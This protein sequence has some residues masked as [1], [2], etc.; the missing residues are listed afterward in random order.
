MKSPSLLS[1]LIGGGL[2]GFLLG[3]SVGV[4]PG[5]FGESSEMPVEPSSAHWIGTE[6]ESGTIDLTLSQMAALHAW[7]IRSGG[8]FLE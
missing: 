8:R 3:H 1:A 6:H 5:T 4:D 2:F 7:A